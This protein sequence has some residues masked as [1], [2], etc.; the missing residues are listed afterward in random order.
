MPFHFDRYYVIW[1]R[2][3]LT[4]IS[5]IHLILF[6]TSSSSSKLVILFA[7]SLIHGKSSWMSLY[8]WEFSYCEISLYKLQWVLK[9]PF[10]IIF[11]LNY[12]IVS[13]IAIAI[14]IYF[15]SYCF[16]F[17]CFAHS[18]RCM[19]KDTM[20]KHFAIDVCMFL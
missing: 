3:K 8:L 20:Q 5:N 15:F 16:S 6:F 11:A 12:S 17:F 1:F 14:I 2:F 7:R 10:V 18:L 4:W 13:F 9:I 19:Q